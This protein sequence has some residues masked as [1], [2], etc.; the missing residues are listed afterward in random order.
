VFV[1]R[2]AFIISIILVYVLLP[3]LGV[4][5][6]SEE[7]LKVMSWNVRNYNLSDRMVDGRFMVQYPKPEDEKSALRHVIAQQDPDLILI[8]EIGGDAFLEE[9]SRD[10]ERE[11]GVRYPFWGSVFV[12][13]EERRLGFLS[14]TEVQQVKS[15]VNDRL[16]FKYFDERLRV[17]RGIL[18]LKID[19]FEKELLLITFHLKSRLSDNAEDKNSAMRRAREA[20]VIRDYIREL[21]ADEP[22]LMLAAIGDLNDHADSSAYRRFTEV[23]NTPLLIEQELVDSEGMRWTYNY[24][25]HRVYEQIDF[26]FLSKALHEEGRVSDAR[27]ISSPLCK[28]A[29]DH[30]PVVFVIDLGP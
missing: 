16:K 18:Q 24:S 8:Q 28:L 21:L 27:I 7:N 13:D 12:E 9:L 4:H 30:R 3:V 29:S 10:L 15:P 2:V 1:V 5:A 14:K 19:Q 22:D 20:R 26:L 17:K 23:S 25:K 6:V 11:Q